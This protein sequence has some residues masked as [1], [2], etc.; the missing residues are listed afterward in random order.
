MWING[1]V[2]HLKFTR[3]SDHVGDQS[4]GRSPNTFPGSH[5]VTRDM[6]RDLWSHVV[7]CGFPGSH[8]LGVKLVFTI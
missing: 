2:T 3:P 8:A 7:M 4:L 6:L 5:V 1:R